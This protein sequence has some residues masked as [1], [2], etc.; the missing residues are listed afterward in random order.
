MLKNLVAI[1]EGSMK[2]D[3]LLAQ[4]WN[5][6]KLDVLAVNPASFARGSNMQRGGD[7]LIFHSMTYNF[8]H[9]D[10]LIRRFWRQGRKRPFF[11]HHIIADDTVDQAM[12]LSDQPQ[13]PHAAKPARRAPRLLVQAPEVGQTSQCPFFRQLHRQP[14][15]A[16]LP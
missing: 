4:D 9:Y 2:D 8:E 15:G 13:E 6:G 12:V 5:R 11:V 3:V 1:G 10:Q 16:H 14:V 7:A